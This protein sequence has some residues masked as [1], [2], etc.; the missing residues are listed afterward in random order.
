ME[1]MPDHWRDRPVVATTRA[2]VRL[3]RTLVRAAVH[4]GSSPY[5][6]PLW[7]S[8]WVLP[9]RRRDYRDSTA[10]AV[11]WGVQFRISDTDPVGW[12][13][14]KDWADEMARMRKL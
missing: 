10:G 13:T 1:N 9:V 14:Q 6:E 11:W 7:S 5:G 3:D 8:R 2:I 12:L 4:A